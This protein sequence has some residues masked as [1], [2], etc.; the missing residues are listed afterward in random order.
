MISVQCSVVTVVQLGYEQ[1]IAGTTEHRIVA[2]S[3][4]DHIVA[5]I[6]KQTIRTGVAVDHIRL[7]TAEHLV[8]AGACKYDIP[9]P[10]AAVP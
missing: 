8:V 3:R 9:A 10:A 5:L 4:G 2:G 7:V 1:V 6:A